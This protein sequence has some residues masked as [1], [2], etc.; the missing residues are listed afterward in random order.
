MKV[1]VATDS[2]TKTV[3]AHIV[4][5][6]WS[7]SDG[8]AI[9]RVAEDIGWLRHRRICWKSNNELAIPKLPKDSLK[10]ARVE[11]DELEQVLEEQVVKYDPK[12]IGHADNAGK[13]VTEVLGTVFGILLL[14]V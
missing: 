1:L 10:T 8:C 2:Q 4:P 12:G 14:D 6:K 9:A 5:C 3:F 13:Q 7:D 11:A